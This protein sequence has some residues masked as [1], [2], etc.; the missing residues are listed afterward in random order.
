[1]TRKS[2]LDVS[3][4][5]FIQNISLVLNASVIKSKVDLGQETE[6]TQDRNRPMMGQSPYIVN[7]G[8]YY[9]DDERKLQVNLLYNVIGRRILLVG[10]YLNP[11]VYEMPRHVIDLTVT[12]NIGPRLELK[13]GIQDILNQQ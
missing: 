3:A 4:S 9:Q 5:K 13:A 12:K 1:E 10:N 2:L 6:Q 7:T 11:T 8:I